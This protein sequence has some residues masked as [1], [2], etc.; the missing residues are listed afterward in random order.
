MPHLQA[1]CDDCGT[2]F[3][4]GFFIEGCSNA[5]FIGNKSGP[6]PNC[7]GM[8][9][10]NYIS[11]EDKE[12]AKWAIAATTQF[13]IFQDSITSVE[14]LLKIQAG[15]KVERSLLTMLHTHVVTAIESYLSSISIHK[16]LNSEDLKRKLVETDP[17]IGKQ[18]FSLKE[19]YDKSEQI[20]YIVAQHLKSIIFHDMKRIKPMF[21]AVFNYVF[22]DIE[23]LFKAILV[24]HDC[25][26]RGGYTKGG[27]A[28]NVSKQSVQELNTKAKQF[29]DKLEHHWETEK[30]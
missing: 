2:E 5:S 16:I 9:S 22:E 12:D 4:S 13:S 18:R 26:H 14:A 23:W 28:V 17:D 11:D 7:G 8:G 15:P 29:I 19:I 24:R 1:V 27:V 6:C 30:I 25:V 21:S 20:E 3:P 10:V